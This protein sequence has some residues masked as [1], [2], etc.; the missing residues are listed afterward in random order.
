MGQR[1]VSELMTQFFI[2]VADLP[3]YHITKSGRTDLTDIRE[4]YIVSPGYP[5]RYP[6]LADGALRI[7]TSTTTV[8]LS[9]QSINGPTYH[10]YTHYML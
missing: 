6:Y 1:C 4:G 8:S 9:N 7:K 5:A 2:P 3:V 10:T